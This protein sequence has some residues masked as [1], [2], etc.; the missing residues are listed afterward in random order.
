M[1]ITSRPNY[2]WE[3]RQLKPLDS[4]IKKK[5]ISQEGEKRIFYTDNMIENIVPYGSE[6]SEDLQ[7]K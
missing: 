2:R 4:L 7:M 6:K 3:S 1:T 5:S